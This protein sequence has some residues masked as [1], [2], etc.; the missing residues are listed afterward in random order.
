[1]GEPMARNLLAAGYGVR[2]WNRSKEK[3][4][5]LA[6]KGTIASTIAR[7]FARSDG[8]MRCR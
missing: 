6:E 5:A 2:A 1:M 4:S 8:R 3:T 7:S